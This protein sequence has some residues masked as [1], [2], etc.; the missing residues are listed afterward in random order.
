M[1]LNLSV[2][3]DK[4][5]DSI[6][7]RTKRDDGS[8]YTACMILSDK[9]GGGSL[10]TASKILSDK[11]DGGSLY[12]ASKILSDKRDD[13]SLYTA[14]KILSDKRGGEHFAGVVVLSR[15]CGAVDRIFKEAILARHSF[16][17]V[18]DDSIEIS[19]CDLGGPFTVIC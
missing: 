15:Y 9:R 16:E 14:S 13:G 5:H 2:L 1:V 12:T 19:I 6:S 18:A 4:S 11:R 10:Y 7:L 17:T 3:L 8:L